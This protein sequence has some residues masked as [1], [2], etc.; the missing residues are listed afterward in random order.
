MTDEQLLPGQKVVYSGTGKKECGV[1]V[2]SWFDDKTQS[3]DCYVAFFGDSFPEDNEPK[4]KPYI[5]R[6]LCSTLDKVED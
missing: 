6:Y 3:F 5:L 4:E 1:V 2:H